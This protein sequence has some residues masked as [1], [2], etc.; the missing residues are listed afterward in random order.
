V[1]ER[2][3][4]VAAIIEARAADPVA[5]HQRDTALLFGRGCSG[6]AAGRAGADDQQI[7]GVLLHCALI[8]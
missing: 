8:F 2:F 1:E 3:G 5:L 6:G 4:G 7:V